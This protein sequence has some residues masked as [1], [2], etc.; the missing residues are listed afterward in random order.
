MLDFLTSEIMGA[1]EAWHK[2]K[3]NSPNTISF[4][5]RILRAVYNRAVEG[6]IFENR[7]PFRYV[8]LCPT[9]KSFKRT[10]TSAHPYRV[11]YFVFAR[12]GHYLMSVSP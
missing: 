7:N 8:S 2:N 4:Y 9:K 1:Y 11:V 5:T 6:E 10:T 3:G 12:H